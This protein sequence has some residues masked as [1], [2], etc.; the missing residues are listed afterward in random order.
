MIG[1]IV[2]FM[3]LAWASSA[4]AQN[5]AALPLMP[6]PALVKVGDGSFLVDGSLR[7]SVKGE[8]DVRVLHAV[9]RFF[10]NLSRRTGIPLRNAPDTDSSN[11]ILTCSSP[12]EKVQT[13]G[14]DESYRLK[15]TPTAVQL[16]AP[17]PLGILRGLQTFLQLVRVGP[18]GFAVPAVTIED[19]PRFPWR[20][21]LMDVSRH[22]MPVAVI[23]RN[24]DGME[25]LKFNVL[26][27]HLSDDQGFRVESKKFPKFQQMSSDGMYYTQEQ[28]KDVIQYARD[29][30][31]RVVPEFDMP[32]H[33]TSWFVAYPELASGP[34][35]YQI[36]RKWGVF[37]PAIDPT[38][39]Q[40]YHFLDE[41]IEE[42]ASLFPDQYFHIG[43]DE[44]NGKAWDKSPEIHEFMRAQGIRNNHDLQAYFNGRLQK[45][46][47]K[48]GKIMT[49]WDEILHPD[50]P[51]EIVV[52]SWRGQKSLADAA[53]QGYR[54]LLSSGYYL[55]LMFPAARHYSVDPL[56]GG[57]ASLSAEE[58]E[59]ILGGEACMWA[60][61]VT[62]GNIDGRIWPR[63]AVVAERLWSPESV[64][65]L[66]SMYARLQ[67]VSEYLDFLGLTH[68]TGYQLML[69]R[70]RGSD[71]IH[72]L[73]VLADVLEP[74]KEYERDKSGK[75]NSFTPLNRLVDTVH[76]ESD[77]ARQF[78]ELVEKWLSD[79]S[80]PAEIDGIR[81]RLTEWRDNDQ[82]LE[83]VL[84]SNSLLQEIIPLSRGL[85][86]VSLIGLQALD[87]LNRVGRA[88]AN[89]RQQQLAM[90]KEAE[91]PQAELLN[92]I[93]PAVEKLVAATTP[94]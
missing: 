10:E 20:G 3:G 42:L 53:R 56:G 72:S 29:R 8:G 18:N 43:G 89:W 93:V 17:N 23:E 70:L 57:A 6:L 73:R 4:V 77:V 44:V 12:G 80:H 62:P 60:E 24:L 86:S 84:Q 61:L 32:G 22:F 91:K 55:D 38:R 88:P 48:R 92:M 47:S 2:F 75:Y 51:R 69:K 30:G 40:T 11:F 76:P 87:Y 19:R 36:E 52:Q 1:Y 35:P 5:S 7:I 64:K 15:V 58:K 49:G 66:S 67:T 33:S 54:G 31:I 21:L 63:A 90:L 81:R 68:N 25:A 9:N 39:D 83:P 82:Q 37:N 79:S 85:Q 65:D 13:L 41:L 14:E 94:E 78:A 71:D 46:V 74:V 45:I 27:W 59:R 34:G 28:I 16:D 26:H 50:L